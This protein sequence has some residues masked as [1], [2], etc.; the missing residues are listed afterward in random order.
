MTFICF[1]FHRV[2]HISYHSI[3][4]KEDS[5]T[6]S[7]PSDRSQDNNSNEDYHEDGSQRL[8]TGGVGRSSDCRNSTVDWADEVD[9]H[10]NTDHYQLFSLFSQ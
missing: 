5:I 2:R 1:S 4:T 8:N 10:D 6:E 3:T 7:H 9:A